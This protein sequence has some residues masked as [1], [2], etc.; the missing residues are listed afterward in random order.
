VSQ[1][2]NEKKDLVRCGF[3]IAKGLNVLEKHFIEKLIK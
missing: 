3:K 1:I 2:Y